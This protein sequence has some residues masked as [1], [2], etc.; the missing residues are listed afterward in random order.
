MATEIEVILPALDATQ[1]IEA[2]SFTPVDIDEDMS[3]VEAL[4]NKN[5]SLAIIAEVTTAGTSRKMLSPSLLQK[6]VYRIQQKILPI[7]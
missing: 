3:I 7:I 6:Q 1:S 4:K 5:N 2:A